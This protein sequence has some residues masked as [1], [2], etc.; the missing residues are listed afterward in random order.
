M[1]SKRIN[2]HFVIIIN[3]IDT[4]HLLT[5]AKKMEKHAVP[6][7]KRRRLVRN[8]EKNAANAKMRRR[9]WKNS[10][11]DAAP[12]KRRRRLVNNSE[13]DAAPVKRRRRLVNNSEKDA[14]PA[15][16]RRR[17]WK[18]SEKDERYDYL[19]DNHDR[20]AEIGDEDFVQDALDAA[21]RSA[22]ESAEEKCGKES[23]DRKAQ[24]AKYLKNMQTAEKGTVL[25]EKN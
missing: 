23:E 21:E 12:A 14:A 10:E 24:R 3:L 13:K 22:Q 7:K 11:K 5:M 2:S 25:Y 9:L 17:H 8:S 20:R 6:A 18:N 4:V 19:N 16:R 15:K 1:N